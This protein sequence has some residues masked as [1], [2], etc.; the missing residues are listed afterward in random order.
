MS[1]L[2][3]QSSVSPQRG[4]P[5]NN[6]NGSATPIEVSAETVQLY[7]DSSGSLTID[8]GQAAG[9]AVVGQT[10]YNNIK[11]AVGDMEATRHD[12]SLSFTSTALTT[13]VDVDWSKI[14][15]VD[16]KSFTNRIDAITEGMANGEYTVDYSTGVIYG[17]KADTSVT[18]TDTSYKISTDSRSA[19]AKDFLAVTP[20]DS[21]NLIRTTRG[22]YVGGAGNV[23]AINASGDPV[24]FI[25][26][27]AGSVLPIE[28]RRVNSTSTTATNIVALF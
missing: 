3:G 4:M 26:V 27:V 15:S 19:P 17:K 18:L 25:G 11:N 20:H 5:T 10:N 24:S 23:V 13:E 1:L 7:Y 16:D 9:V 12:T 28:T 22:L 2:H 21:T 6:K 14:E 8:A